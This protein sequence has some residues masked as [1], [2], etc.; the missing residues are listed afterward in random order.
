VTTGAPPV[1][2]KQGRYELDRR[3][4]SGASGHDDLIARAKASSEG[5]VVPDNWGE[6]VELEEGGGV[7]VGRFRGTDTDSRGDTVVLAWDEDGAE[8]FFWP[9]YRLTQGIERA[10]PTIGDTICVYRG[11]NYQTRYDDP[12]ETSG[13]AYG[14][15][16]EPCSDPLPD[17]DG[18]PF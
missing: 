13:L 4:T 9:A 5:F 12:G 10:A 8:R 2:P 14:V 16:T 3:A 18:V 17:D 11:D 1:R 6:V 7:F 15:E